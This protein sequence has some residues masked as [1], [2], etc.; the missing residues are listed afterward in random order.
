MLNILFDQEYQEEAMRLDSYREGEEKGRQEGRQ[1]GREEGI[2]KGR[3][4]GRKEVLYRL[5]KIGTSEPIIISLG[6]TEEEYNKALK[7]EKKDVV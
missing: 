6:Y 3:E 2:E 4:E 7:G 1:E 5:I